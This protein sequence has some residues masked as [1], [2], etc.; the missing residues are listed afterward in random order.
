MQEIP[1]ETS[2]RATDSARAT[3]SAMLAWARP[4]ESVWLLMR[5]RRLGRAL[6]RLAT[7]AST[8]S[9]SGRSVALPGAKTTGAGIA[10]APLEPTLT[11]ARI[12]DRGG[13]GERGELGSGEGLGSSEDCDEAVPTS[14]TGTAGSRSA[15]GPT[16]PAH[17]AVAT[18]KATVTSLLEA[19]LATR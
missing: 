18:R 6:R 11:T 1:L 12:L 14:T 9:L 5:S 16:E 3:E 19:F 10:T 17:A 7:I 2:Q 13:E 4:L 15:P 8:T